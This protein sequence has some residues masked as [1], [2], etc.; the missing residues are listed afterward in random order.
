MA[1]LNSLPIVVLQHCHFCASSV[2]GK[3][4]ASGAPLC[5]SFGP[6]ASINSSSRITYLHLQLQLS[7]FLRQADVDGTHTRYITC[8]S[9]TEVTG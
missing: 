5:Q 9:L 1:S 6:V 7:I 4:H 2:V 3:A 8:C